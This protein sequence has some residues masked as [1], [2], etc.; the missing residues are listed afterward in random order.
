MA[1]SRIDGDLYVVGGLAAQTMTLPAAA[2]S[3]TN[4]AAAAAIAATKLQ[5]QHQ[6]TLPLTDHATAQTVVRKAIH[7]VYGTTGTLIAFKVGVTVAATAGNSIVVDLLKNGSSILTSTVTVDST[8]AA[9]AVATASGFTS[10]SV[11]TGDLL[12]VSVTTVTGTAPKGVHAVLI[13]QED[14]Q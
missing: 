14:A 12:E 10:A 13:V 11:S 9:Y 6:L 4:V 2:V 7:K 5:H 1:T 3:N 8:V